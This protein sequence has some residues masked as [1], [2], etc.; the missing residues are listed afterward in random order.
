MR[1]MDPVAIEVIEFIIAYVTFIIVCVGACYGV[2][3]LIGLGILVV[4]L[5]TVFNNEH[6]KKHE[7]IK[8]K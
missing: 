8:N 4:I 6:K 7:E 2:W 5:M 3:G 1:Q